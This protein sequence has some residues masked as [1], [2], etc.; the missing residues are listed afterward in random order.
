MRDNM[1]DGIKINNK[2]SD[3]AFQGRNDTII[4]NS[5]KYTP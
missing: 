2:E 1:A 5:Q 3:N 4:N